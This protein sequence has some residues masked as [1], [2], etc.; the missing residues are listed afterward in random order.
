MSESSQAPSGAAAVLRSFRLTP[1]FFFAIAAITGI[2][3]ADTGW[4]PPVGAGILFTVTSGF[5][6][7][8]RRLAFTKLAVATAAAFALAHGLT[9]KS[10]EQFP[11]LADLE[12]NGP[13]SVEVV[14][15][16][17]EPPR[18]LRSDFLI[19]TL[20][21]DSLTSAE[22]TLT[23]PY[24]LQLLTDGHTPLEYGDRIRVK[25]S[26]SLSREAR[27]P[28]GMDRRQYLRRK[29]VMAEVSA[30]DPDAITVLEKDLGHP[31]KA[32]SIR[33][34]QWMAAALA[35][36]L[37]NEPEIASVIQAMVLGMREQTPDE[38]EDAFRFSGTLHI[39]RHGGAGQG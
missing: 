22:V 2:V 39:F 17:I 7:I 14:G 24:R 5:V 32:T 11:F 16:L 8:G 37:E 25:G 12:T 19:A 3:I 20:A 35:R 23:S 36:D 34:R 10:Q 26:L 28:G 15:R 4:F 6:F 9:V 29:G 30:H 1:L 13:R 38:I 21:V 18:L 33:A 31:I 27:N